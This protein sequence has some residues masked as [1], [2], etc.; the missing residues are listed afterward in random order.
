[1]TGLAYRWIVSGVLAAAF[2]AAPSLAVTPMPTRAELQSAINAHWACS[3]SAIEGC[4]NALIYRLSGLRCLE[5][6]DEFHPGRILCL[7]RG[8]VRRGPGRSIRLREECVYVRR[9]SGW[10]WIVDAYPDADMCEH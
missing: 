7:Y 8:T 9:D 10:R 1:M 5:V 2:P 6:E 3:G 4:T